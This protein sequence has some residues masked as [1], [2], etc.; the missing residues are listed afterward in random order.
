M[1]YE[2]FVKE[3]SAAN[4]SGREVARLLRL[5]VNTVANYKQRGNVPSNL[6]VIAVLMRLLAEN[7]IPFRERLE[8]LDIQP[9]AARGKS[10]AL[11]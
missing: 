5:N 3:L 8:A 1:T 9:N 7:G 11:K 4:I 10:I 2:D 6:V